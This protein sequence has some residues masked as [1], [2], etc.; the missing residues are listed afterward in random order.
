MNNKHIHKSKV[1]I[2]LKEENKYLFL[3]DWM[4]DFWNYLYFA[5]K[6]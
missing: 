4:Y 6:K 1:K 5:E 3:F 2:K